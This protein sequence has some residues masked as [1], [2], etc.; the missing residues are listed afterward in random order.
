MIVPIVT[1]RTK[2]G[3]SSILSAVHANDL[4]AVRDLLLATT[5]N[6]ID[7]ALHACGLS[8]SNNILEILMPQA[9]QKSLDRAMIAAT[10]R[11]HH[12][13]VEYML[14]KR[15]ESGDD[16][17][18]E[19]N[20]NT[21]N[22]NT[23]REP[24]VVGRVSQSGIDRALVRA[25]SV[26]PRTQSEW[27]S[28]SEA[29][30]ER[31]SKGGG[32]AG[33]TGSALVNNDISFNALLKVSTT[34]AID[35]AFCSVASSGTGKSK[36]YLLLPWVSVRGRRS[37]LLTAA[38]TGNWEVLQLVLGAILEAEISSVSNESD[39]V[40]ARLRQE[41]RFST[42]ARAMEG[43]SSRGHDQCCELLW[44]CCDIK[45]KKRSIQAAQLNGHDNLVRKMT[46]WLKAEKSRATSHH[47]QQ[48]HQDQQLYE[49]QYQEYQEY[50]EY[51]QLEQ[52]VASNVS[53]EVIEPG[54]SVTFP[55]H[56]N[57]CTMHYSGT[58]AVDGK[59]FDSS[60]DRGK[61]FE[62]T[63]GVGQVIKGWDQGVI[64][65]SLGEKARMYIPSELGYGSSG[66][67][68]II[69]PN[70]DLVFDVHLLKIR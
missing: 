64:Q 3:Y 36:A 38:S 15:Q 66:S 68:G 63:V 22:K 45:S 60:F 54:D 44:E 67:G 28:M 33:A 17:K 19:M 55:K 29:E 10:A 65:M 25:A 9:T 11:S 32:Y 57:V 43:A 37:G 51:Q 41:A 61:P 53:V 12:H 20:K 59:K 30:K 24:E 23:K 50:Q 14:S 46:T 5:Q 21:T 40:R 13:V 7:A 4:S 49:Q 6:D 26:V 31:R 16:E 48:Q 70:A 52:V 27:N 2:Y 56:G 62:F 35:R 8:G 1:P 34:P 47:Y 58:L 18:G 42:L 39:T 69:P